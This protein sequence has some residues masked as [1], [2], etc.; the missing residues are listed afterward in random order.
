MSQGSQL[1][2]FQ[3]QCF[4]S[5]AYAMDVTCLLRFGAWVTVQAGVSGVCL[6]GRSEAVIMLSE[7]LPESLAL[8]RQ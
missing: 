8:T 4:S 7:M 2:Q 3:N 1:E 6:W 5:A